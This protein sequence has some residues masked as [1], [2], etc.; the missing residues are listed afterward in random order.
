MCYSLKAVTQLY[1]FPAGVFRESS[2]QARW[3]EA[4]PNSGDPGYGSVRVVEDGP[5]Q[6]LHAQRLGGPGGQNSGTGAAL[7]SSLPGAEVRQSMED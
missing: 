5:L 3:V 7:D 2:I 6:E 4:V 1:V